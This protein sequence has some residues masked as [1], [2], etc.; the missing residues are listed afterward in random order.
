M[1]NDES[2]FVSITLSDSQIRQAAHIGV[3]RQM[4]GLKNKPKFGQNA[5]LTG[6]QNHITGALGEYAVSLWQNV[7]YDGR[8]MQ[9]QAK[10][11][12]ILQVRSTEYWKGG[13]CVHPEDNDD[14]IFVGVRVNNLPTCRLIGWA[15][16]I[17]CKDQNFWKDPTGKNRPAFFVD[18]PYLK[19]MRSPELLDIINHY[20]MN[21]EKAPNGK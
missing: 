14:D 20:K 12:G 9:F 1:P 3:E 7:F 5:T 4:V 16:A 6:W 18:P 21:F 2:K 10:D 8:F 19:E 17:D 13:L 11:S 15:W